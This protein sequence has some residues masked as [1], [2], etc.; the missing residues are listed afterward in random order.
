MSMKDDIGVGSE[1][2]LVES[3]IATL[4]LDMISYDLPDNV[5]IS[6]RLSSFCILQQ[7]Y[8]LHILAM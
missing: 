3:P 5:P 4:L 8:V 1:S 6:C 7:G 2:I